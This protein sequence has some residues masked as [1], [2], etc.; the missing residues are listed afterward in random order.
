MK[1]QDIVV[2]VN[3]NQV[4]KDLSWAEI[5]GIDIKVFGEKIQDIVDLK[6]QIDDS[7]L[8]LDIYILICVL[9]L[10]VVNIHVIK[11]FNHG[12]VIKDEVIPVYDNKVFVHVVLV[13]H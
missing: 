3:D 12:E 1:I 10:G 7:K 9:E 8:A 2:I 4:V 11:E 6:W 13:N 5:R